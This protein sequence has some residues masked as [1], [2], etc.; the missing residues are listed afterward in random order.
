MYS[1]LKQTDLDG[2]VHECESLVLTVCY[3][4]FSRCIK[5]ALINIFMLTIDGMYSCM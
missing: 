3:S 2:L 4:R 1:A 5:A